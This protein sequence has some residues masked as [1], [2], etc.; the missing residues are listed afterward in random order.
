MDRPLHSCQATSSKRM[1]RTSARPPT[2]SLASRTISA[3]ALKPDCT[4]ECSVR[5]YCHQQPAQSRDTGRTGVA[6]YARRCLPQPVQLLPVRVAQAEH[7]LGPA[8]PQ[9][10]AQAIEPAWAI[11]DRCIQT[12]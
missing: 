10:Q 5:A 2:R 12:L 4:P 1:C 8:G 6:G 9:G 7:T 3:D 11:L